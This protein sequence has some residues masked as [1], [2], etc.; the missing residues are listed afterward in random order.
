MTTEAS[1]HTPNLVYWIKVNK[2]KL[3]YFYWILKKSQKKQK[4]T[5]KEGSWK[6]EMW[7]QRDQ[8]EHFRQ[9]LSKSI[10]ELL[11]SYT[12]SFR[13][14]FEPKERKKPGACNVRSDRLSALFKILKGHTIIAWTRKKNARRSVGE[15]QKTAYTLISES[16]YPKFINQ[17]R[18]DQ[19]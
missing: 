9:F 13:E 19:N 2:L 15:E 14:V 8:R 18:C 7:T 11:G 1:G 4:Q 16:L 6:L 12:L 3:F 5:N 10:Y 17:K